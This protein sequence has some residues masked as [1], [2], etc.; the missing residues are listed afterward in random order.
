MKRAT[1]I[2]TCLVNSGMTNSISEGEAIVRSVF[3]ECCPYQAFAKWN[4]DVNDSA[5][6]VIIKS[7][8]RA[9]LI[10]VD[11][12]IKDLSDGR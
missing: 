5:A 10:Q 4:L 11:Q 6:N 3:A 8:G 7:V 9:S 12:L 1:I 2:A